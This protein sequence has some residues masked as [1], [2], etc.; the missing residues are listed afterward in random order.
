MLIFSE[1]KCLT[2]VA[3]LEEVPPTLPALDQITSLGLKAVTIWSALERL[4]NKFGLSVWEWRS[5]RR[6]LQREL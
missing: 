6:I 1:K 4:V 5:N 2:H 3:V